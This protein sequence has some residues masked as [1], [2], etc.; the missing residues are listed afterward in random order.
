MSFKRRRREQ[1]LI[2]RAV[3]E[4]GLE[5][6]APASRARRAPRRSKPVADQRFAATRAPAPS[7]AA[8]ASVAPRKKPSG[9]SA[10]PPAPHISAKSRR[11][12]AANA[13]MRS[14]T[15]LRRHGPSGSCTAAIDDA[16]IRAMRGDELAEQRAARII[17]RRCG[18]IQQPDRPRRDQQARERQAPRLALAQRAHR[19]RQAAR[20]RALRRRHLRRPRRQTGLPNSADVAHARFAL[21]CIRVPDEMQR[22]RRF[23]DASNAIVPASASGNPA[24]ARSKLVLPAPFAPRTST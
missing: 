9:A 1:H 11:N 8:R 16:A 12:V 18:L 4:I 6:D 2:E 21:Q 5:Q 20:G 7:P 24:I 19:Q 13:L 15:R 10:P 14:V 3:F 23:V 17:E 22:E